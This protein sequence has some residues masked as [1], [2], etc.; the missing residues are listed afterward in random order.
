MTSEQVIA[1]YAGQQ[2]GQ[3]KPALADLAVDRLAPISSEMARLM[4]DPAEIDRILTRGATRAREI[5]A[6]I[7][8]K[9]YEIV[10]MVRAPD[11]SQAGLGRGGC[12]PHGETHTSPLC[13]CAPRRCSPRELRQGAKTVTVI[14]HIRTFQMTESTESFLTDPATRV[15]HVHLKVADLERAIAFYRD[16]M[17]FELQ[18]RFGTDAAFLGAGG[19][20]HHIGLNTSGTAGTRRQPPTRH[21]GLY[22]AAF[23]YPDRT[24]ARR[25]LLKR[26]ESCEV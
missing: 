2:F 9:T 17:G 22:H 24:G 12:G 5:T 20:H 6:P 21:T 4:A 7:L 25:T 15:G 11:P 8:R 19:Y 3:F 1:E 23:L 14:H 13:A 26:A 18:Q 16:V 10:G